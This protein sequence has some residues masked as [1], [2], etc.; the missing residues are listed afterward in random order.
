[1]KDYRQY[2]GMDEDVTAF[3]CDEIGAHVAA[4]GEKTNIGLSVY[5]QKMVEPCEH[6]GTRH[7]M[8]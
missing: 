8:Q 3:Y 5:A 6:C 1:M 2:T 7:V 4:S